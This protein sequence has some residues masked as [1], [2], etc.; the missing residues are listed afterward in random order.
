MEVKRLSSEH[1][2]ELIN[3]L[4]VVF[5]RE[6]KRE[7]DFEKEMPKMCIRDD[8]HIGKHF[9][10][11]ED[12]KLVACMGVY[13]FDV[14]VAG[15]TMRFA[16]TGNI[17]VHWDCEGK[18][19]MGALLEKAMQELD[20]LKVDAAR[21]GGLRSRYN[22]YGFEACGQNYSFVFTEKNRQRKFPDFKDNISFREITADDKEALTFAASLYNKNAIAVPRTADNVYLSLTMWRNTPYLAVRDG[23][24]VGYL[25]ADS[26]KIS[27]AEFEAVDVSSLSDMMCAW[28]KYVENDVSFYRQAHQIDSVRIFSA[29]CESYGIYSPSHFQIRNWEKVV[30]AFFKL[31]ASY[32]AVMQGELRVEIEGYGVIRMFS[33][34]GS[35]GCELCNDVPDIKL[36]KLT[37]SRFIFGLHSPVSTVDAPPIA[38]AWFPLPLSWN[39]QDRV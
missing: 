29:V 7:M 22:R 17:A 13:P 28:Q 11:F 9:G 34:N 3:L 26:K 31:K 5:S 6:N 1:Y 37:A 12:N 33:E 2:D 10:I 36:D 38:Q 27:V 39:G 20:R 8:E 32:C 18:G 30:D 35:V 14:I 19:Y 24:P 16:T 15:E 21:L 25:C 23:E 4:N